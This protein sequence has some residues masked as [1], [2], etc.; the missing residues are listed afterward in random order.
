MLLDT[1]GKELLLLAKD[2]TQKEQW[3]KQLNSL[4]INDNILKAGYLHKFQKAGKDNHEKFF[5]LKNNGRISWG[6]DYHNQKHTANIIQYYSDET[7]IS[8]KYKNIPVKVNLSLLLYL[9]TSAKDLLLLAANATIKKNW[10][11]QL[12]SLGLS[13]GIANNNPA[14]ILVN[15]YVNMIKSYGIS[16]DQ[17]TIENNKST[18]RIFIYLFIY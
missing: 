15:G 16:G 2:S 6:Y 11:I 13:K 10:I 14:H 12:N 3:I 5:I 1:S 17:V 8:A 9:E 18:K 7:E 4:N